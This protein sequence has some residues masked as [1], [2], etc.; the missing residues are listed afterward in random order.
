[1]TQ[2]LRTHLLGEDQANI[3]VL[4]FNNLKF[5][6]HMMWKLKNLELWTKF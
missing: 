1:M 5:W 2:M 3:R 6:E 4:E